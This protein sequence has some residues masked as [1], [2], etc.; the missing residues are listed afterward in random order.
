MSVRPPTRR[1]LQQSALRRDVLDAA[2]AQLDAGGPTAV[3]WRAIAR[4]VGVSPSTLYTYFD[5]LDALYT[6][7]IIEVYGLM[8]VEVARDVDASAEPAAR[9]R[10]AAAGYRRFATT[11]PARFSLVFVDVLPGYVAPPGGPTIA[12]QTAVLEPLARAI[13]D[14]TGRSGIDI[15]RWPSK[16]RSAVIGSW[17]ELHG[18]VS[19]EANHH[20]V[21]IADV[22][23]TFAATVDGIVERLRRFAA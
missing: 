10:A 14:L 11:Y 7:L 4:A 22:D 13:A 5:S 8:A 12:A 9:V 1:E 17:S 23:A 15:A 21:W 19:L 18:F 2:L 3:N 6:E 20:L 16:L